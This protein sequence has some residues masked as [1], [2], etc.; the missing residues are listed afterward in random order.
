MHIN[1][2]EAVSLF[3]QLIQSEPG[4]ALMGSCCTCY[5]LQLTLETEGGGREG[6]TE[7]WKES[8]RNRRR[9]QRRQQ[10]RREDERKRQRQLA[11][12]DEQEKRLRRQDILVPL[13][14]AVTDVFSL[15]PCSS[16]KLLY[17]SAEES[18]GK[19]K[20]EFQKPN[21]QKE[22]TCKLSLQ[23]CMNGWSLTCH[24]RLAGS[25]RVKRGSGR[26]RSSYSN[27]HKWYV[28]WLN[29]EGIPA[30]SAI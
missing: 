3:L 5:R 15:D 16:S 17:R 13:T 27:T 12:T 10:R 21:K 29:G 23:T 2:S 24:K 22:T 18:N 4:S 19:D 28:T 11:D 14:V 26:R 20:P 9:V 1:Y 30:S 6:G 7:G 8:G 25:R